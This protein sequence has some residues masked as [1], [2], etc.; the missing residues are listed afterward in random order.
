MARVIVLGA[1]MIGRVMALDLAARHEVMACDRS[2]EVLEQL[3]RDAEAQAVSR[4][5][6]TRVL[7]VT[8]PAAV[9]EAVRD[10]D[11]VVIAVP[12][13]IGFETLGT[14][15]ET[16]LPIAD[17]SFGP[18]DAMDLDA[19]AREHGSCAVVD[20]GVAPGLG[21]LLLGYH[22][23]EWRVSEFELL[24]GGL[25]A[26]PV[27]PWRYRAPF[28]PA[29][30]IEEYLR[31]ARLM[32][33]GQ[34]VVRPALSEPEIIEFPG[35]GALEAFNTDGLRTIL[36]TMSHIPTMREKTLR[37]P[38]H[39]DLALAVR[40]SGLLSEVPV[41]VPDGHG[42]TVLVAPR[43]ATSQLLFEQW[44]LQPGEAEFTAMRVTIR[45]T[46]RETGTP[47][48]A[49]IHLL[50]HTDPRTGMTSMAR[51][52]GYTCTAAV[53][54]LLSG[55]FREPGVHPGERLGAVPGAL[56][57]VLAYLAERGVRLSTVTA[58]A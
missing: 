45:G 48:E 9:R 47:R 21:S 50:D 19:T 52:T 2:A 32:E 26:E 55:G 33:D 12:G 7:D 1:G 42:G 30:V 44:A 15:I 8:D 36:R 25:P 37:W 13:R 20:I 22:D 34:V 53:E 14:V 31:P 5:P 56:D 49:I 11:L 18:E 35:V 3:A 27:G 38:G 43:A 54:F 16:G 57:H 17:I 39:R 23:V 40:E 24:V 4:P 51:T 29:D 41:N 6:A 10:A 46:D 58:A 28:S